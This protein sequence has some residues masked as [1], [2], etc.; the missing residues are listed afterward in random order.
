M[1]PTKT[2]NVP[3]GTIR[4]ASSNNVVNFSIR[5]VPL[6]R[7]ILD[8][9]LD[10]ILTLKKLQQERKA[11]ETDKSAEHTHEPED[12]VELDIAG[13]DTQ[14]DLYRKP[15]VKP[16]QFWNVLQEK[17]K[18]AGPEWSGQIDRIWAF[19]PHRAG[20]CVLI[21]TRRDVIPNS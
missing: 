19:G 21:D 8:F 20:G 1:A 4:G 6:P 9:L 13:V 5:A 17:C 18:E 15:T 11:K 12:D 14:G 10:N 16:E 3:R 2:P 7:V